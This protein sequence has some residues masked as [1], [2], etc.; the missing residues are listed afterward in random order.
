MK[1]SF[2][3]NNNIIDVRYIFYI[4][5]RMNS[6]Q[7]FDIGSW[8]D[9]HRRRK[10]CMLIP[11]IGEMLS[12]MGLMAAAYFQHWSLGVTVFLEVIF[13][14]VTGICCLINIPK[15]FHWQ[16]TRKAKTWNL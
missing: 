3:D 6:L 7:F 11:L 1:L 9:R 4:E 13:P 16:K 14:A 5:L 10:P 8:S 2:V 15:I 12:A